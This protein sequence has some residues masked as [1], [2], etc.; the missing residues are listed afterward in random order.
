MR[1]LLNEK[2]SSTFIPESDKWYEKWNTKLESQKQPK[3]D[4]KQLFTRMCE[5]YPSFLVRAQSLAIKYVNSLHQKRTSKRFGPAEDRPPNE[6]ETSLD[7]EE[8]LI[9]RMLHLVEKGARKVSQQFFNLTKVLQLW[10]TKRN[11]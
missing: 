1:N 8:N 9:A 5:T 11:R 10:T 4:Q 2:N 7:T 6:A 3:M